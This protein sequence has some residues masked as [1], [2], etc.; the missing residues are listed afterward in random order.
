MQSYDVRFDG[1]KLI[2]VHRYSVDIFYIHV[3]QEFWVL[4]ES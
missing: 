3:L 1:V 2:L 4:A